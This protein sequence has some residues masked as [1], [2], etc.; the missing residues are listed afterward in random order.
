MNLPMIVLEIF[1]KDGK[2][3]A[4]ID[5]ET[6]ESISSRRFL[7]VKRVHKYNN[8]YKIKNRVSTSFNTIHKFNRVCHCIINNLVIITNKIYS[9]TF[10]NK[11][12]LAYKRFSELGIELV[13]DIM[14]KIG[15][16]R[17]NQ[18]IVSIK[19]NYL[20]PRSFAY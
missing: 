6:A 7:Q 3:I 17:G 12:S 5:K 18:I 2:Q 1:I 8:N 9:K 10:I 13:V 20:R 15:C 4:L 14:N 11:S 19:S 16:S